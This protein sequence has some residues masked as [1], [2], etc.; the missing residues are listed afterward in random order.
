MHTL[1]EIF[2][3][4][5]EEF[6]RY[7]TLRDETLRRSRELTRCCALSIR[8]IHR[9]EW[10]QAA[11]LLEAARQAA[12]E[13]VAALEGDPDLYFAGYTQD[14]LKELVEA[15]TFHALVRH[16]PLPTPAE[17]QV[18][19]PAYLNGLGEAMGEIRR[20][21]LDLIRRGQAAQAEPLLEVMDEVYSYLVTVD[22]P[23]A[24]TGGLRRTTDLV[25][26][27]LER[28]RGDLTMAIRQDQMRAALERLERRL[29]SPTA[30]EKPQ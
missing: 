18:T 20:Y 3:T 26:S 7:N 10:D 12:T 13:M 23:D 30:Q 6:E 1:A 22:F 15:H 28:T 5:R 24:V 9:Q 21:I 8:A 2:E 11:Q 14:A 29:D 25:R 19:Y 16:Q 17:L 27:A 4:I